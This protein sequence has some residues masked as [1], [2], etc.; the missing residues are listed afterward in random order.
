M[1]LEIFNTPTG[2]R[3][4]YYHTN[5]SGYAR[6]YQVNDLPESVMD[7][8]YAFWDVT[9][10]GGIVSTDPWA[11]FDKRFTSGGVPPQDT[12]N[13]SGSGMYGNFNQLKK[14]RDSGRKI[15]ATL[16]L[17]GWTLSKNFSPAMSTE[18]TRTN[19]V[20][21]IISAF[22]KYPIFT[23]VSLDW[24]YVS[25]DGVNHGNAGNISRPEDSDNF[26]LFLQKLR[27][28]FNNEP[29]MSKYIIAMCCVADPN[30]A[31]FDV[32]GMHPYLDELHIM[33]YDFHDGNWGDTIARH[34]TN[35]RKSQF[36]AFSCEEAADYYINRGVPSTKCFIGVAF[37]SR[38]F[39]NATAIGAPS[40]GGS[41]DMSWDKGC[42]DYKGLPVQGATEF[43][44]TEAKAA[45][46]YDPVKKV[47]NSYDNVEST[48]EKCRI[49]FEKN[50]GGILIW[51]SSAD[52]PGN[53]SLID[54]MAK[55]LTHGIVSP[56]PAAGPTPISTV[57]SSTKPDPVPVVTTPVVNIPPVVT[58]PVVTGQ[59]TWTDNTSYKVNDTVVYQGEHYMCLQQHT[60]NPGW[61]PSLTLNILWIKTPTPPVVSTPTPPVV[62]TCDCTC[63]LK[64]MKLTIDVE[65]GKI[66]GKIE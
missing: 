62:S 3:A 39:S 2:K 45:Y 37:Y 22:K 26:I 54:T 9:P 12:W 61:V 65:N 55:N 6:D 42:V 58:T 28:A 1:G 15:N 63:K 47:I 59:T 31:K 56:D 11:D 10:T 44:D 49:V 50:L 41:P 52:A 33:T 35:P 24:E 46:S 21:N 30:K 34:H 8:S 48:K 40:S 38:G 13:D 18:Q 36:S 66:S 16:S 43:F 60:S 23:G 20:N 53:R 32:E 19:L 7:I 27:N 51:E 5:W 25:N 4:I 17:G 14:L 57:P 29:G 64:N